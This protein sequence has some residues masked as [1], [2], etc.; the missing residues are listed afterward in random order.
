MLMLFFPASLRHVLP[1][2]TPLQ[3]H[4]IFFK[5]HFCT[6]FYCDYIVYI[7]K[8]KMFIVK[9]LWNFLDLTERGARKE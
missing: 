5:Y 6:Y 9:Y 4:F 2:A 7:V 1:C 8:G 3:S